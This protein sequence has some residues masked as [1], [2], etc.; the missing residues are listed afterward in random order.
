LRR[1]KNRVRNSSGEGRSGYAPRDGQRVAPVCLRRAQ[2]TL[3]QASADRAAAVDAYRSRLVQTFLHD[4]PAVAMGKALNSGNPAERL[5]ALARLTADDPDARAGLQRAVVDYV[6]SKFKSTAEAGDTGL[7]L[8]KADAFQRFV[9]D[10]QVALR[11]I[12]PEEHIQTMID[13]ARDL[14]RANR[15]IVGTKLPGQS[16]SPQDLSAMAHHGALPDSGIGRLVA[17]EMIGNVAEGAAHTASH[18]LGIVAKMGGMGATFFLNAARARGLETVN[19]IV[20]HMLLHPEFA[21]TLLAKEP[22]KG[23]AHTGYWKRVAEQLARVPAGAVAD[24][25]GREESG[26]ARR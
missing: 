13:V 19:D 15:S 5:G 14:Q 24:E 26:R 23:P 22:L 12:F 25:L 9:R 11:A 3:N 10:K 16:N 8:F 17:I 6:E 20:T 4:D 1:G 2:E 18:G 21:R 7:P